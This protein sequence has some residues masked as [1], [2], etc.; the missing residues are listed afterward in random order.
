MPRHLNEFR[1]DYDKQGLGTW[2]DYE[3]FLE[4]GPDNEED[5]VDYPMHLYYPRYG[6]YSDKIILK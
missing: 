6:D 5:Y 1:H 2:I 3:E 4:N